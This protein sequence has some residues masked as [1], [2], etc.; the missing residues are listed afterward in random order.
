MSV[1]ATP[2]LLVGRTIAAVELNPFEDVMVSGLRLG[3]RYDPVI[4]LDNGARV[5]FVV[6][7]I[8]SGACYGVRPCYDAPSRRK[9]STL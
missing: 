7:E 1:L 2:R 8:D 6:E 4:V 5:R 9:R 3:T